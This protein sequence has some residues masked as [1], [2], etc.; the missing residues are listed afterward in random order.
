MQKICTYS[1]VSC[2]YIY[3]P[4]HALNFLRYFRQDNAENKVFFSILHLYKKKSILIPIITDFFL[5][6]YIILII[7]LPLLFYE[8][9]SVNVLIINV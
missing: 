7:F 5:N 6:V 9:S 1:I 2:H 8:F 4:F 3:L